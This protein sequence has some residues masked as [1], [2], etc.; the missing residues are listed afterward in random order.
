MEIHRHYGLS[1][2]PKLQTVRLEENLAEKIARLNRLTVARDMY[3]LSWVISNPAITGRLDFDLIR[4][5][6]LLKIWVDAN[7]VHAGETYWRPGH[8]SYPFDPENWLRDRSKDDFDIEDIGALAIPT[9]TAKE[10]SSIVSN[11]FGFLRDM[12]EDEC[13]LARIRGQDRPLALRILTTLL[14][15]RLCGFTLY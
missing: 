2:L 10:L 5:L 7:G 8:A 14:G 9:P 11:G 12:D 1:P 15:D 4:R 3:D 13:I 6:A